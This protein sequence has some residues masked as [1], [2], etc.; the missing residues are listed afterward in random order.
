VDVPVGDAAGGVPLVVIGASAGGIEA[1]SELAAHLDLS[2]P[3]AI[4]VVIHVAPTA[5]S[6]LPQIIERAGRLP[7]RHANDGDPLEPGVIVIC[8]PNRQLL[9]EREHIRLHQ[10]PREHGLRPAIDPLFRSAA[11]TA[12]PRCIGVILSGVLD[13]G[14][15]GLVAVKT[16]GGIAIVQDPETALHPDMPAAA[17]GHLDVDHIA[18]PA[19]IAKAL[20]EV[21]RVMGADPLDETDVH[22]GSGNPLSE[23]ETMES[24]AIDAYSCPACHGPLLEVDDEEVLRFRCRVGHVWSTRTLVAEQ[25]QA[26]E[27]ALWTA[28][29]A[30]EDKGALSRRLSARALDRGRAAMADRFASHA[31]DVE[32]RATVIRS[33]LD[34][35]H[36][37]TTDPSATDGDD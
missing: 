24:G 1:L 33:V 12:G 18:A 7:A 31:Q 27:D 23:E 25:S 8:P 19:A 16:A 11:A 6:V 29:R 22:S 26:L 34:E 28:L 3:A 37:L 2:M 13:D 15:A 5:T 4:L 30:L 36:V 10:G 9:V 35:V 17:I 14:T 32:Q 20:G 21:V